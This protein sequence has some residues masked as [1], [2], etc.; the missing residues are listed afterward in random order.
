MDS[1]TITL[2]LNPPFLLSSQPSS[3]T[4]SL[5]PHQPLNLPCLLSYQ[6]PPPTWSLLP[7]QLLNPPCLLSSQP[8]PLT[9]SLVPNQPL[10]P[11]CPSF[12]HLLL[13]TYLRLVYNHVVSTCKDNPILNSNVMKCKKKSF[14]LWHF[15]LEYAWLLTR[16]GPQRSG[17]KDPDGMFLTIHLCS[18]H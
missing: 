5:P 12:L 7:H 16:P 15:S 9:W 6:P 10:N 1:P 3:P 14:F 17:L 11:S 18:P 8:P 2:D 13:R 4:W